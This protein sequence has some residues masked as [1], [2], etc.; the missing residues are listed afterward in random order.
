MF[1]SRSLSLAT[2]ALTGV[3]FKSAIYTSNKFGVLKLVLLRNLPF[4]DCYDIL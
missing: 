1:S 2:Y 4:S 3:E